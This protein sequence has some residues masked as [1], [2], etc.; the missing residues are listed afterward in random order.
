MD[1]HV[2]GKDGQISCTYLLAPKTSHEA[3]TYKFVFDPFLSCTRKL[4]PKAINKIG[5]SA[6]AASRPTRRRPE[7][8]SSAPRPTAATAAAS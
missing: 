7:R 3:N 5:P 1:K 4:R 2:S 8:R 6:S